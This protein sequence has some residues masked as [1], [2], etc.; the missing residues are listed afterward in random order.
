MF[1]IIEDGGRQYR[2][3]AGDKLN[4]DY[5]AD[6]VDGDALKFERV[7]AAGTDAAGKI[8]RPVIDG[9]VV[10]ATVIDDEF[11][12]PKLEIGKFRRRKGY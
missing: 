5:R 9:A 2:V 6:L 8:G 11:R 4:V 12:G 3:Q 7:L 10:E 1:A